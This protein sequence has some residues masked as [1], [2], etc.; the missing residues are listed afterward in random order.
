MEDST[1]VSFHW[2]WLLR[3]NDFEFFLTLIKWTVATQKLSVI[4]SRTKRATL[5]TKRIIFEEFEK[6]ARLSVGGSVTVGCN[7]VLDM[8]VGVFVLVLMLL[9]SYEDERWYEGLETIIILL[10]MSVEEG[11]GGRGEGGKVI[12]MGSEEMLNLL[13]MLVRRSNEF[14]GMASERVSV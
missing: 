2:L 9:V 1:S 13:S 4:T 3:S 14:E 7:A 10:G 8:T 12:G 5:N 11:R 6:N